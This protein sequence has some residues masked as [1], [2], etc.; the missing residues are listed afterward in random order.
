MVE[1]KQLALGSEEFDRHVI[2]SIDL[3]W[4]QQARW[5]AKIGALSHMLDVLI[6]THPNPKAALAL[7]EKARGDLVDELVDGE[8]KSELHEAGREQWAHDLARFE[9]LLLV[10]IEARQSDDE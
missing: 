10:V 9:E 3:L 2:E 5:K 7:L 6:A 8:T 4:T 1:K